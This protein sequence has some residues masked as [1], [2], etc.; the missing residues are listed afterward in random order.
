ML[1]VRSTF[2]SHNLLNRRNNMTKTLTLRSLDI[3]QLHKFGIG[4]DNM[5]DESYDQE[6]DFNKRLHMVVENLNKISQT[7]YSDLTWDKL[8]H[9]HNHFFN[10]QLCEQKIIEEIIQ[11]LLEYAET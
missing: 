9:N 7:P 5:F 11:P 4:F 6:I 8:K 2:K 1:M 10:K 3:P